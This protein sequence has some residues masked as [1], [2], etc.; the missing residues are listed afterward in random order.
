M[1]LRLSGR[2]YGQLTEDDL[3]QGTRFKT[4]ERHKKESSE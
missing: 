1:V 2:E 3:G 4:F